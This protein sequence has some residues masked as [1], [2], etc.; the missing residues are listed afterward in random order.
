VVT[1]GRDPVSGSDSQNWAP[2]T[3][4]AVGVIVPIGRCML[5][6]YAVHR[7]PHPK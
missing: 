2:N 4:G 7:H 6:V 3:Q 5:E 1:V